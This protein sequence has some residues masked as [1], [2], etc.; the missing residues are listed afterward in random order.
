MG[1]CYFV[2]NIP[3]AQLRPKSALAEYVRSQFPRSRRFD[4][5]RNW[6][7]DGGRIPVLFKEELLQQVCSQNAAA[8]TSLSAPRPAVLVT[9]HNGYTSGTQAPPFR[10][11]AMPILPSSAVFPR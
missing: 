9:T 3:C 11:E 7:R 4:F 2:L 8:V 1:C 10:V 5:V 6:S